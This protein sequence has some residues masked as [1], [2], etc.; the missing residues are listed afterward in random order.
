MMYFQRYLH[1]ALKRYACIGCA[2]LCL[3]LLSACSAQSAPAAATQPT[4]PAQPTRAP[5]LVPPALAALAGRTKPCD[6]LA[7]GSPTAAGSEQQP[8]TPDTANA[9][10][11]HYDDASNTVFLRKGA[12]TTLAGMSRIV[13]RPEV[14]AQVSPGE[15]LLSAN[16]RIEAGAR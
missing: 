3:I 11:V 4:P 9:A 1:P 10:V 8:A 2:A 16:L 6:V 15:W 14:L 13:N 5:Q 12:Q 7:S